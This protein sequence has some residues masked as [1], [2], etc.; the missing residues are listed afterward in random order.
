MRKFKSK[1][2][3]IIGEYLEFR[4]TLGYSNNQEYFLAMFDAYYCE[5]HPDLE[6][7]TKLKL[8]KCCFCAALR[9]IFTLFCKFSSNDFI[10]FLTPIFNLLSH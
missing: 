8:A 1:L 6:T 3:P 9:A 7:M 2:A 10:P 4:R 5:Y